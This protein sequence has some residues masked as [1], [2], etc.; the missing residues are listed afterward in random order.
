[1]LP[2]CYCPVLCIE[3]SLNTAQLPAP[4]TTPYP[5]TAA[6]TDSIGGREGVWWTA[7]GKYGNNAKKKCWKSSHEKNYWFPYVYW[8][9]AAPLIPS[10]ALVCRCR[11]PVDLEWR[12]KPNDGSN[13]GIMVVVA[14]GH[15]YLINK[16]PFNRGGQ[17]MTTGWHNHHRIST[18]T[19]IKT[20]SKQ[21]MWQ[22][23]QAW[24]VT[25]SSIFLVV[26]RNYI[27]ARI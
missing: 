26:L 24:R 6:G 1:M 4:S 8:A 18:A 15:H 12:A 25:S 7:T 21:Q 22:V 17:K 5:F 9:V 27:V 19:R 3:G 10:T 20:S 23:T 11:G 14:I 2:L 16:T 13:K